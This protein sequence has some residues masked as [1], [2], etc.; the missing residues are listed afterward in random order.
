M[1]CVTFVLVCHLWPLIWRPWVSIHSIFRSSMLKS[2]R[3]FKFFIL[4]YETSR[5]VF[6]FLTST[7]QTRGVHSAFIMQPHYTRRA[8]T[9]NEHL[10]VRWKNKPTLFFFFFPCSRDAEARYSAFRKIKWLRTARLSERS[11]SFQRK[12]GGTPAPAFPRPALPAVTRCSP[13]PRCS[14]GPFRGAPAR[15]RPAGRS[16]ARQALACGRRPPLPA[17]PSPAE[18]PGGGA[19]FSTAASDSRRPSPAQPDGAGTGPAGGRS[20]PPGEEPAGGGSPSP[21]AP[22]RRAGTRQP[23]A[24][25]CYRQQPLG[26]RREALWVFFP[27]CVCHCSSSPETLTHTGWCVSRWKL[28]TKLCWKWR[29]VPLAERVFNTKGSRFHRS[30]TGAIFTTPVPTAQGN[31]SPGH[32]FC[33]CLQGLFHY[34]KGNLASRCINN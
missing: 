31:I 32:Y 18:Q 9:A 4:T 1:S 2:P 14:R 29:H 12:K 28:K 33:H 11:V 16:S 19:P 3:V 24:E 15:P 20:P 27:S 30:N 10:S 34:S 23:E 26:P 6:L 8:M 21:V 7:R 25:R 22:R 17:Q 13:N 5:V